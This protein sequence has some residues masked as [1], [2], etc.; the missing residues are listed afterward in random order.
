MLIGVGVLGREGGCST[1]RGGVAQ[2]FAVPDVVRL[3]SKLP[4]V[5]SPF[6]YQKFPPKIFCLTFRHMHRA[7]NIVKK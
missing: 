3:H 7:L 6:S 1:G 2:R 5:E 4:S